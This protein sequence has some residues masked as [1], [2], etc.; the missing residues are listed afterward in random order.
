M[1]KKF[2]RNV[3]LVALSAV[4]LGGTAVAFAGCGGNSDYTLTASIFCN[5]TDRKTN[6]EICNTWAASY[7]EK[8]R[9]EGVI[10]E[11][12]EIKVE[13]TTESNTDTY[14]TQLR[15]DLAAGIA[16]DVF[17]VSPKYVKTWVKLGR[18]LDL[19]EYLSESSDLLNDIWQDSLGFYAYSED[20]NYTQG[21]RV[22]Y[23]AESGTFK[24]EAGGISCGLYALPKD[25]SNFGLGVNNVYFSEEMRKAY[26][27]SYATDSRNVKGAGGTAANCNYT[28]ND[29]GVVTYAVDGDDFNAGDDA[30]LINIGI[31]TTYKPYN[32]YA[33]SSYSEAVTA[34]DPM[35]KAVE[36][37][38]DGQG[39]TVTIPG[40]PGEEFEMP[41]DSYAESNQYDA[42]KGYI[43]YTYAEYGALTWAVTYYLN[44]FAWD[45]RTVTNNTTQGGMYNINGEWKNVYGNDQ[46][47]GVLYLLPWLAGN[48]ADYIDAT[49]SSVTNPTGTD[50]TPSGG[51][52]LKGEYVTEQ[53][54]YGVN[55]EN[56]I[57]TFAAF[58]AYGSDWNGNSY[59]CGDGMSATAGGWDGFC[60]GT[61]VF[62]GVGTWDASSLN[63]T[64]RDYLVYKLIPEPVSEDFA[65]YSEIKNADYE[66]QE[67]GD[68]C[69]AYSQAEIL[70]NQVTRQ[71]QWGARMDSVGYGV[72]AEVKEYEGT[73][74][75]WKIEGAA[76][77]V[78]ALTAQKAAQLTLTYSGAQLPNFISQSIDYLYYQEEGY[79]DGDFKN[80]I[81]PDGDA[82][83][84]DVW[85]EYYAI[86]KDLVAHNNDTSTTLSQYMS[87]NY[88]GKK[89]DA[90]FG[91]YTLNSITDLAF[92]MKVLYM[93]P[94]TYNDRNICLRMQ[95]GLNSVRDSAMYTYDD[96]WLDT[97]V[98]SKNVYLLAYIGQ[99][100]ITEDMD[101]VIVY[102]GSES[103][104]SN[105]YYTPRAWCENRVKP[106]ADELAKVKQQEQDDMS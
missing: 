99:T 28:G 102:D 24:T 20:A 95:S 45:T 60:E 85:D 64:N 62:Y 70:E 12:T 2:I 5:E 40:W 30:P 87:Q 15:S 7:T 78:Q 86:A 27:T 53:I 61:V 9:S 67:Y 3:S 23:D 47:E 49:A 17:Y 58:L 25:Y 63:K 81:T 55:S 105:Q 57:E 44:T 71:D 14:F 43:T 94:Y 32:F 59:Y 16:P 39:Y 88:S 83:G 56:F 31:P 22:V 90:A 69:R 36:Q 54:Q 26:T 65:L 104:T 74:G 46:Y 42:S 103:I 79:E 80:M 52:N 10:D 72:N 68:E 106:V 37:L 91:S 101:R 76:S 89:Y 98:A 4:M 6:E 33:Y 19:T 51:L 29:S 96:S 21:E 41:A 92:A 35:A 13:L 84:N 38:T 100:P 77:L 48:D 73:A 93:I 34:G 66:L 1:K 97:F 11:T 18:V 50:T 8:L 82:E 75:E